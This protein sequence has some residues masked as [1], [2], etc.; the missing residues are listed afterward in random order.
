MAW[1]NSEK[2]EKWVL[3]AVTAV[4]IAF[5]LVGIVGFGW[6]TFNNH[7]ARSWPTVTGQVVEST[8]DSSRRSSGRTKYSPKVR[9]AYEVAGRRFENNHVWLND[10]KSFR[11]RGKASSIVAA[12]RAGGPATI[13]YDPADPSR[14]LLIHADPPGHF[15]FAVAVGAIMIFLPRYMMRPRRRRPAEP[16]TA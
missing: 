5:A 16:S 14:S 6:F 10:S 8:V 15:L 9:Y 4:G 3:R 1:R 13:F 12:Y 7:Q 11:D 2:V